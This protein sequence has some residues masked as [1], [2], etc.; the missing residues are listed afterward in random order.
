MRMIE[1]FYKL[2]ELCLE[3]TNSCPME[4]I[5]CSSKS[6]KTG[7][8]NPSHMPISIAKKVLDEFANIGGK[9]LEIS[10]GEP[11][12]YPHLYDLCSYARDLKLEV[13]LYTSGILFNEKNEL[14]GIT[15]SKVKH[16]IEQGVNK[17]IF[18]L[19]GANAK[20]H[21]KIIP[22]VL[23]II[24]PIIRLLLVLLKMMLMLII[25]NGH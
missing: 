9:I 5:H 11:L 22:L 7:K 4:C 16:L 6:V 1:M 24:F 21:Q 10:G 20:T 12:I 2:K 18:N 8:A 15:P 17:I 3:I 14:Q 13:R 23:R 25:I 19:E